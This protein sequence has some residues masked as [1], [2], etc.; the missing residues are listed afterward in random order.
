MNQLL[1]WFQTMLSRPS[2]IH[3]HP[4]S[5]PLLH[6][7]WKS[8]NQAIL[9]ISAPVQVFSYCVFKFPGG[10]ENTI[11]RLVNYLYFDYGEA[12]WWTLECFRHKR[13]WIICCKVV[14]GLAEV[15]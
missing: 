2:P 6:P 13:K 9:L 1:G 12:G 10:G 4:P 14:E 11:L 3:L 5:P 7:L 8:R 15:E